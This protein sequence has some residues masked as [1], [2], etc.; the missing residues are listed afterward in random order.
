MEPSSR[1]VDES[2]VFRSAKGVACLYV[3]VERGTRVQYV[4]RIESGARAL[5]GPSVAVISYR[6]GKCAARV[7][8]TVRNKARLTL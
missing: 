4:R 7:S 1:R 3:H 6:A 2:V 5:G 8:P